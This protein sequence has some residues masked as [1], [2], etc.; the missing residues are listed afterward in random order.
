MVKNNK[1]NL[2]FC[3]VLKE[4]FIF[5]IFHFILVLKGKYYQ[6]HHRNLTMT[7]HCTPLLGLSKELGRT[8]NKP[9]IGNTAKY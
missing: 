9:L 5:S 6:C 2:T 4:P 3:E 7:V 8:E 1:N